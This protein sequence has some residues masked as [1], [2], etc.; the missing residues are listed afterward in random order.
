M[1]GYVKT[2]ALY[3]R[4]STEEQ[5]R[6]GLASIPHQIHECRVLAER[7]GF[8]D[9]V[10]FIED[11][12]GQV[13]NRPGMNQLLARLAEFDSVYIFRADR[14]ARRRTV[15]LDIRERLDRAGVRLRLVQGDTSSMDQVSRVYLESIQDASSE[16]YVIQWKQQSKMGRE[17]RAQLGRHA[18]PVPLGYVAVRNEHGYSIGLEPDPEWDRFFA[19]LERLFLTGMPFDRIAGQLRA[20][21]HVSPRTGRMF[22]PAAIRYM[23]RNPWHMGHVIFGHSTRAA[24]DCVKNLNAH[25]PRWADP[26]AVRRELDRRST[27][28]GKGRWQRTR[29]AGLLR[30]TGCGWKLT[31]NGRTHLTKSGLLRWS[32]RYRCSKHSDYI[33]R[34]AE[35]PCFPN[36]IR[37]KAVIA[38]LVAWFERNANPATLDVTLAAM[39]GHNQAAVDAELEGL[40]KRIAEISRELAT[41]TRRL[42]IVPD[43][44]LE[45]V[46]SSMVELAGDREG[47]EKRLATL[48]RKR[49]QAPDPAV[50]RA[51]I[52]DLSRQPEHFLTT[53]PPHE[54]QSRLSRIFPA[55][56]YVSGGELLL[57]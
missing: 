23:L 8:P 3:A 1:G 53:A 50:L 16:A 56:I 33:S 20:L 27:L 45:D 47:H 7:D 48:R 5:G 25:P 21:G 14:M 22:S 41:L 54:V 19:E 15:A 26:D 9:P 18:G 32:M 28:K 36:Y 43:G 24:G 29:F 10:Q 4:V 49:E 46:R 38:Q 57:P 42:A 6:P 37:E 34:R 13:V 52:L 44:A 31:S 51:D 11:E 40:E 55:G 35:A 30:C 12:T 39:N 2:A 17:Y